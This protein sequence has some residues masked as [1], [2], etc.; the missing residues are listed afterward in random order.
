MASN[1]QN[2]A[3]LIIYTSLFWPF[4]PTQFPLV[5]YFW[6]SLMIF[7]CKLKKKKAELIPFRIIDHRDL[8]LNLI[9]ST[10]NESGKMI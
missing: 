8:N 2:N 9:I 4:E 1:F 6:I 10:L 5:T 3:K 7:L